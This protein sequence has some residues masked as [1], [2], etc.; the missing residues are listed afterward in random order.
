MIMLA[1]CYSN[2]F[3][4]LE[5]RP[6]IFFRSFGFI[7]SSIF[8]SE[9]IFSYRFR[10]FF[11][12]ALCLSTLMGFKQ[13]GLNSGK[14]REKPGRVSLFGISASTEATTSSINRL[15]SLLMVVN[16]IGFQGNR[17]PRLGTLCAASCIHSNNIIRGVNQKIHQEK[18]SSHT[19]FSILVLSQLSSTSNSSHTHFSIPKLSQLYCKSNP[20][21]THFSIL[22]L[23]QLSTQITK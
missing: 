4:H 3:I 21:H 7:S 11:I 8:N 12:S 14:M 10:T 22:K 19:H 23:S 16:P 5:I 2:V 13:S 18:D 9:T 15:D 1:D 20:S 6:A 17:E